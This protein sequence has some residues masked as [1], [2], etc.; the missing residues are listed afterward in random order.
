MAE[1]WVNVDSHLYHPQQPRQGRH[2]GR[3]P[4]RPEGRVHI[5]ALIDAQ[6]GRTQ[7]GQAFP[8]G[9]GLPAWITKTATT[10]ST[11]VHGLIL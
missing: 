4:S 7:T 2:R 9:F 8:Q 3:C 11:R 1:Y 5:Q 10:T 6:A